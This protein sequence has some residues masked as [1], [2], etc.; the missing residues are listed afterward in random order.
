MPIFYLW[1]QPP[2]EQ[3][4]TQPDHVAKAALEALHRQAPAPLQGK[5]AGAGQGF[6]GGHVGLDLRS[7]EGRKVHPGG[8]RFQLQQAVSPKQAVSP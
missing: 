8:H 5:S 2:P 4:Q 6:P 7:A 1:V 3:G